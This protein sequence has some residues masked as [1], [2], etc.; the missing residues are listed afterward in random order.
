MGQV[1]GSGL[2]KRGAG[3][4]DYWTLGR[5]RVLGGL[6]RFVEI[7]EVWDWKRAIGGGA[8]VEEAG[9]SGEGVGVG[10]SAFR[11]KKVG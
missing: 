5:G 8:E 2:V 7:V 11:D 1:E 10:M 4:G 6:V 9:E 3:V